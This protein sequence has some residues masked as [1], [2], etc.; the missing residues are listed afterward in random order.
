MKAVVAA[1]AT[2]YFAV[3]NGAQVGKPTTLFAP[4]AVSVDS[5]AG[6]VTV[7]LSGPSVDAAGYVTVA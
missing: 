4:Q 1:A 5:A 2:E 3:E 7:S 6:S